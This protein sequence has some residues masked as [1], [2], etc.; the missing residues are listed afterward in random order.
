MFIYDGTT[1]ENGSTVGV[2]TVRLY[3]TSG[4]ARWFLV[5][6]ELSASGGLYDHPVGGSGAVNGSPTPVLWVA[7][8]EKAYAEANA[9][10]FVTTQSVGSNCYTALSGGWPSWALR[11]ITGKP[12]NEFGLN[13]S[14]LPSAWN[15]GQLIVLCTS[16]PSSSFIVGDHCYAVVG[17]NPSSIMP[18]EVFNPWGTDANGWAPGASGTVYGLF[19]A[20]SAILSQNFSS[21]SIGTGAAPNETV[22]PKSE[23]PAS[24]P[25]ANQTFAV[26]PATGTIDTPHEV[27]EVGP[28]AW[29]ARHRR[30]GA[31]AA[32][33]DLFAQCGN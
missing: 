8:A 17:Y 14:S 5:D 13:T 28:V 9:A 33:D 30:T 27:A 19:W 31:T 23:N 6:T 26:L 25:P 29:S 20:N 7:L 4:V 21:Q 1:V 3:D 24:I 15:A 18:F 12:A 11:A 22:A 2:Y 10:G 32:L 16:S